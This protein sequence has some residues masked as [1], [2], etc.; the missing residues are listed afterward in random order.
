MPSGFVL[1]SRDSRD[2]SMRIG[3]LSRC[4]A[5]GSELH[6]EELA[7]AT[8]EAAV[9]LPVFLIL[10]LLMLQPVCLLY[11][12]SIMESTAAETARLMTTMGSGDE[13]ACRSFALRRLAAIPDLE[14]FHVGGPLAWDIELE[15]VPDADGGVRVSIEGNVHP[16]PILGAFAGA[17]GEVDARGDVR[18]RAAVSYAA[19]PEWLEGDYASWIAAWGE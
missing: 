18:L 15:G 10:L 13:D 5:V 16:L 8:V 9:L 19:R 3:H 11:T 6:D 14:I 7:Q 2:G 12:R 1:S 17:V 4:P